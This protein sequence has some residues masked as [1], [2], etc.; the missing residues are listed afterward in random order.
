MSMY[1]NLFLFHVERQPQAPRERASE[2]EGDVGRGRDAVIMEK[3]SKRTH[4][5]ENTFYRDEAG[6]VALSKFGVPQVILV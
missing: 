2:R 6:A 5:I 1:F 4:S 3:D